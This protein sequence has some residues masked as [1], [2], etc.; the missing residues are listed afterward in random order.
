M[1]D[2]LQSLIEHR[3][4]MPVPRCGYWLR[5]ALALGLV[6]RTE[7]GVSVTEEGKR[8]Y[9]APLLRVVQ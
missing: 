9:A 6:T 3:G 2:F 1:D 5:K 7:W 4:N 8:W